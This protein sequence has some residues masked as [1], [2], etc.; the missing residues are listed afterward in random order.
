MVG[1][2]FSDR[3]EGLR[4]TPSLLGRG[5]LAQGPLHWSAN[6]DELQDFEGDIRAHFG[7]AGLMS[8]EDFADH[9]AP[10][11]PPKAGLSPELDALATY[12][13]SLT[14]PM[15]SPH[16]QANGALSEAAKRGRALFESPSLGCVSCH[17]GEQFS[18]SGWKSPAVPVLHD[19][20]TLSE[21]SPGDG[22]AL[23]SRESTLPVCEDCG[24]RRPISMTGEPRASRRSG[25][26]TT[27]RTNT[28]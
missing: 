21:S 19:V 18:D 1:W 20:G 17:S 22:W 26:P 24:T 25:A 2:D 4:N 8:D 15:R 9:A 10:L 16:R 27:A 14:T 13:T 12:L 28:A 3:G 5:G 7:G 6:F 11:G 23:H